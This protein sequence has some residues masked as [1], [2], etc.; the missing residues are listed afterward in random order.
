M[1]RRKLSRKNSRKNFRRSAGT[2][3]KN[4]R[5]PNAR[6]GYRL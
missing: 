3:R 1:R 2:H 4:T 6:G 5:T